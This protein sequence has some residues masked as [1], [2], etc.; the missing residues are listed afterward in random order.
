[1]VVVGPDASDVSLLVDSRRA[2]QKTLH[3][4][5]VE[6]EAGL[7]VLAEDMSGN[8]SS[9]EVGASMKILEMP[10]LEMAGPSLV[11]DPFGEAYWSALDQVVNSDENL[12]WAGFLETNAVLVGFGEGTNPRLARAVQMETARELGVGEGGTGF[13]VDRVDTET[14]AKDMGLWSAYK[15]LLDNKMVPKAEKSAWFEFL[16]RGPESF[17]YPLL[18]RLSSD[19][20]SHALTVSRPS[21]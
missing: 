13:I 11:G 21:L 20:F 1:M 4:V 2:M 18:T 7:S 3:R 16:K 5:R 15:D 17:N 6:Q 9:A 12:V 19:R 8:W 14:W 10:M